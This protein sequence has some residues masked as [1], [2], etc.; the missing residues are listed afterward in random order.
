[1]RI[2]VI[3]DDMETA[4]YLVRGLEE[5]GHVVVSA[6]EGRNGLMLAATED[7][8]VLFWTMPS[9]TPLPGRGLP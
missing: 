2:L 1:M 5:E 9:G 7:F 6:L 8:D 3:E 4:A